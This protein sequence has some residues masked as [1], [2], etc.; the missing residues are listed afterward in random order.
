VDLNLV[1]K[2][3]TPIALKTLCLHCLTNTPISLL[4]WLATTD[5]LRRQT[6]R[7]VTF[8][9]VETDPA[10]SDRIH[11]SSVLAAHAYILELEINL[12]EASGVFK[13][14]CFAVCVHSNLIH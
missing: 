2:T 4:E 14:E 1:S 7:K 13:G 11:L 8:N 3:Y 12:A 9:G 6:L 5:T 10:S